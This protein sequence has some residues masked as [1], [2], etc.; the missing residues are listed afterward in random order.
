[1]CTLS[2]A[3]DGAEFKSIQTSFPTR[4]GIQQD[5]T[6]LVMLESRFIGTKHIRGG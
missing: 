1:M 6:T 5:I 3:K 4:S 2:I